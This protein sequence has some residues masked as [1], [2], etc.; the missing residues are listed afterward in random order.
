MSIQATAINGYRKA[1]EKMPPTLSQIEGSCGPDLATKRL[2]S[3]IESFIHLFIYLFIKHLLGSEG[4]IPRSRTRGSGLQVSY[5]EQATVS[6]INFFVYKMI[7]L[8]KVS[9]V[10]FTFKK[11]AIFL[12][13]MPDLLC[14]AGLL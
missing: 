10:L 11:I 3:L 9:R 2:Y 1:L 5:L 14:Q 4:D 7:R 6:A 12:I 8:D 13:L